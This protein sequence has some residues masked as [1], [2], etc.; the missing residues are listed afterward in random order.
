[1]TLL[2]GLLA[3]L[4]IAFL[5]SQ[6]VVVGRSQCVRSRRRYLSLWECLSVLGLLTVDYPAANAFALPPQWYQQ[7]QPHS[8]NYDLRRQTN[9]A[10]PEL[11]V[12]PFPRRSTMSRHVLRLPKTTTTTTTM[13]ENGVLIGGGGGPPQPHWMTHVTIERVCTKKRALDVHVFRRW[14]ITAQEHIEK[15][16]QA[17]LSLLSLSSSSSLLSSSSLSE[18]GASSELMTEDDAINHL[19]RGYASDGRYWNTA[20]KNDPTIQFVTLYQPHHTGWNSDCYNRQNGVVGAVDIQLRN[21]DSAVTI[22]DVWVDMV[23]RS[24]YHDGADGVT[25]DLSF[26]DASLPTHVYLSNLGVD[27]QMQGHGLGAALMAAVT[28]HVRTQT[29][30]SMILLTVQNDNHS[31][32]RV[33][34]REGYG[35]LEKNNVYGRMFKITSNE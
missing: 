1:M 25:S 21:A 13:E 14:S 9:T 17:E 28:L 32:I 34:R 29:S 7:P 6:Q 30:A 11:R 15:S 27:D 26:R 18:E 8:D 20:S 5:V 10:C 23:E 16:K 31:A 24:R 12:S 4:P 2:M 35:Y 22:D 3:P 19:M 33:Y